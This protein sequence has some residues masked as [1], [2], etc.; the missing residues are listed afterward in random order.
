MRTLTIV[1][2]GLACFASSLVIVEA[3][4]GTLPPPLVFWALLL[5]GCVTTG[6][7]LRRAVRPRR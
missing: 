7:L 4:T 2:V 5:C 6:E 1:V 3:V